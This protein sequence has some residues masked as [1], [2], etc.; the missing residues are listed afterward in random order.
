MP[1]RLHGVLLLAA[2]WLLGA[3]PAI[4]LTETGR[5]PWQVRGALSCPSGGL[6]TFFFPQ[7][8]AKQ[9]LDLKYMN[10]AAQIL[11][12]E[13]DYAFRLGIDD[14]TASPNLMIWAD[15]RTVDNV[16]NVELSEPIVFSISAG[17]RPQI[18]WF[19]EPGT[20]I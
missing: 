20:I 11:T 5:T 10:C 13:T 1:N 14:A 6:C 2:F 18:K 3:S 9:R 16:H 15:L 12:S 19:F 7:V 8:G 4:A 17:H